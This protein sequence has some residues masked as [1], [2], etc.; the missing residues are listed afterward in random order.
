MKPL[1][2]LLAINAVVVIACAA[3]LT[4]A[5]I[6]MRRDIEQ[7]DAQ[8]VLYRQFCT[9]TRDAV[10]DDR[11]AFEGADPK[12]QSA[13]LDRFHES[14]AIYHNA[15]SILMCIEP[16]EMPTF[17]AMCWAEKNMQCM[18]KAAR[19]VEDALTKAWPP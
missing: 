11:R 7:R 5:M 10:H 2:R 12:K 15:E 13:A 9:K 1:T 8:L 6:S 3:V 4:Y 16:A 18:E 17:P 14:A 19:R